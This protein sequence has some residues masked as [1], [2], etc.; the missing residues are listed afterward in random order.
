MAT[1]T[2]APWLKPQF[3]DG[4]GDPLAGGTLEFYE[5][6]TV[7]PR[8][9]FS[10]VGLTTPNS[11]PVVLDAAGRP[12]SGAIYFS[13]GVSYK[14]ICKN[15]AG[16][17][18]WSQDNV[19]AVPPATVDLDV[20]GTAGEDIAA[21][22]V[23]YLSDGG[24]SRTTG[25]WY[26][27]DS[28]LTYA[29]GQ[30][31]IVGIAPAAI[32]SGDSGSIRLSGRLTGLAGL[33]IGSPYYISATAGGLTLTPTANARLVGVADSL[34]SLVLTPNPPRL[35]TANHSLAQGRLTLTSG[36]PVTTTDVS[37]VGV[38]YYT[39]YLGNQIALYANSRWE[40]LR[41]AETSITL[42]GGAHPLDTNFDLFAYNNNGALALE[43]LAWTNATTRATALTRQDGVLVKSGD[44][45]RRYLGTFRTTAAANT[46]DSEAKRFLWN[47]YNRVERSL[48]VNEDVNSWTYTTA[49]YRQANADAANQVGVVVGVAEVLLKVDVDA[50][51]FNSGATATLSVAIGEDS[52][53]T[54][55]S[56][57]TMQ[58][59]VGAANIA[60]PIRASLTKYP[61]V[62][63]HFYAWLEQSTAA[64]TSTWYGDNNTPTITQSGIR[65]SIQG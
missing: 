2:L 30:G 12:A 48:R 16:A 52:T 29:S 45:T 7:N 3:F 53:T 34:T 27:T 6:G 63:Y 4:N 54:P 15:S 59:L 42:T 14:C 64:G 55:A 56:G 9:T 38:I 17:I 19:G 65:G 41:F 57:Q 49:V 22:D 11:N 60:T 26:K 31:L 61:A 51:G 58:P 28:D 23:V 13:P 5:A 35:P 39:P 36:T 40:V 10:D 44:A 25:R 24:G 1:G 50:A 20:T 8:D 62:G 18:Q 47:F 46:E 33:T 21:G 43:S 32:G 37:G